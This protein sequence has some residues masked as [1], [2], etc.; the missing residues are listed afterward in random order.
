MATRKTTKAIKIKT[1][2]KFNFH[3]RTVKPVDLKNLSYKT[4]GFVRH[5]NR[6]LHGT[7]YRVSAIGD[8]ADNPLEND[9]LFVNKRIHALVYL[10]KVAQ[11][12]E[13]VK[14]EYEEVTEIQISKFYNETEDNKTEGATVPNIRHS[15]LIK[16]N[17]LCVG[18]RI[19]NDLKSIESRVKDYKF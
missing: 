8:Y 2:A 13:G 9:Y 15:L 10:C 1:R 19:L 6:A 5:L 3:K 11:T 4:A 12:L 17:N 18:P 7:S 14:S 16:F